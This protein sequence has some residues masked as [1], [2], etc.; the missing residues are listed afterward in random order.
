MIGKR[1][2]RTEKINQKS[3]K[4]PPLV[5]V[6][7]C[8]PGHTHT[9]PPARHAGRSQVEAGRPEVQG[10]AQLLSEFEDIL[11]YIRFCLKKTNNNKNVL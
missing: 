11:S 10:L 3:S 7:I 1:T 9:C 2:Q 6:V 5:T 4:A 8:N